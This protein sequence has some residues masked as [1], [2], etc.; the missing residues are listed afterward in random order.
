MYRNFGLALVASAVVLVPGGV[1]AQDA[2]RAVSG[3]GISVPGWQGKIDA[4]EASR[5]A[6][7]EDA[8]LVREGRARYERA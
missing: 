2:S 1:K 6:K 5:G 4:Q 7:L 3:G 8:K